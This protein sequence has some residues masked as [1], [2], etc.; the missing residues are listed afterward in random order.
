MHLTRQSTMLGKKIHEGSKIVDTMLQFRFE[1]I[2]E[3]TT[4]TR[5]RSS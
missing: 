3:S 1:L 2:H 5:D 4:C